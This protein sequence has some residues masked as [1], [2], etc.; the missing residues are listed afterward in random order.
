MKTRFLPH[1]AFF[2][3]ALNAV[4]AHAAPP[5]RMLVASLP[6]A[7]KIDGEV[8]EWPKDRWYKIEVKPAVRP[9]ERMRL[10]LDPEDRNAV[11]TITVE[12]A[13]GVHGK[14]FYLAARWPD[15]QP[16]ESYKGWEWVGNRYVEGKKRDDAFAVRF[17]LS[18]D[19]DRSMLSGKS[20]WV[21][22]WLWTAGRSNV[23]GFAEDWRHEITLEEREGAAE[24]EVKG[25]GTVYIRK[26][27]DAGS[28][29]YR[30]LPR[31]KEKGAERL[32]SI[33]LIA[34]PDGSSADVVA[35]GKWRAGFWTLE[36]A[37]DLDTGHNDDVVL[38][39]GAIL[40]QIAVFNHAGDE[41]KSV[42][43]PLLFDFVGH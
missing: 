1:L 23:T 21:D 29:L 38:G 16:D 30:T 12:L 40:G 5:Q 15:E 36:M 13:V 8:G 6:A 37:R 28:G 26:I 14:R 27:R 22:V 39:K 4:A 24:Y 35:R 32:P 20:Y 3:F 31:P 33:E 41:N 17:H 34:K 10:G 25:I 7:P 11:G 2:A 18:G 43:E 19:Y 9:D 42:S